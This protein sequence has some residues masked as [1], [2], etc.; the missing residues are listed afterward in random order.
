MITMGRKDPTAS[1]LS[2]QGVSFV[3]NSGPFLIFEILST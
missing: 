1:L 3:V 2:E